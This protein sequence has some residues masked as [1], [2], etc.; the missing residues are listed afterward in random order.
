MVSE[1]SVL[2]IPVADVQV[3]ASRAA[4]VVMTAVTPLD[5]KDPFP[6]GCRTLLRFGMR[7]RVLWCF[8]LAKGVMLCTPKDLRR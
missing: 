6:E 1:E 5:C 3:K 7:G 2:A 8:S 4:C